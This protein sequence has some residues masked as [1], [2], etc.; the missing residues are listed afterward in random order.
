MHSN[1]IL[2][3]IVVLAALAAPAAAL[4]DLAADQLPEGYVKPTLEALAPTGGVAGIGA[5]DLI[6]QKSDGNPGTHQDEAVYYL[7]KDWV[8]HPFPTQAIYK[9]W[10]PSF[11][12][13][14]E[15][16][17]EDLAKFHLGKSIIYRPG[18][19]LVKIPSI[20]KVYAVEPSGALRWIESESVA[21][22]LYG[23]DWNKRV[24][25]VSE[26]AFGDYHETVS[27]ATPVW[28][29]GT[30]VRRKEDGSLFMT[31]GYG[32][33]ALTAEALGSMHLNTSFAITVPAAQI[34]AY[35]DLGSPAQDERRY[36]D[37]AQ[38]DYLETMPSPQFQ[39]TE[40][41]QKLTPGKEST[42]AALKLQSG[43]PIIVKQV[44]VKITG[45]VYGSGHMHF[46]NLHVTDDKG[47]DLFGIQQPP[48]GTLDALELTFS[49]AYTTTADTVSELRLRADVNAHL[50]ANEQFQVEFEQDGLVVADGGNG[51]VIDRYYRD[52][53]GFDEVNAV[54]APAPASPATGGGY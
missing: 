51:K 17:P 13:V 7:D 47:N 2:P 46:A 49:G 22:A 23:N 3:V 28:P 44:K 10:Y 35:P 19:R 36:K 37:T 33:R 42:L 5:G 50:E 31:D 48:A 18:T 15:L 52:P 30:V 27:L 20:P 53:S 40:T 24:D 25:D 8:R 4:A 29:T 45:P 43:A 32:R 34:D 26:T 54:A 14:K 1:R 39:V 9:S 41:T 12:G 11:D 38:Q 16:S 21:K 6:K